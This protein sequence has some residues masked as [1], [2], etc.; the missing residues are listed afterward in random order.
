[1]KPRNGAALALFLF[2]SCNEKP[3]MGSTPSLGPAKVALGTVPASEV[4]VWQ[5]ATPAKS[6]PARYRFAMAYYPTTGKTYV[7]G[8][9]GTQSN[10]ILGDL[11]AWDGKTWTQLTADV[12]PPARVWSAM[13]YDPARDSLILYGGEGKYS[14]GIR[15]D[16]TWEWTDAK[17]WTQLKP[18]SSTGPGALYN[19]QM[20]TDTIRKKVLLGGSNE[21]WEW[22]G[23]AMTWSRRVPPV[24]AS[25]EPAGAREISYDE[26]R[27]KLFIYTGMVGASRS[28]FWELDLLSGGAV[29]RDTGDDLGGQSNALLAY[30]SVRRRH[31]FF[32]G[33]GDYPVDAKSL[34]MWEVDT[35]APTWYVRTMAT[36][37]GA[38][39]QS[40]MVFD[41]GRNV[42]V[43]FGGI[44]L[45]YCGCGDTDSSFVT[46]NE[47]W[48]YKVT[49]LGNGEGCTP[50]TAASCASGNCVE[51]VCCDVAACAGKCTSCNVPGSEGTCVAAKAGAEVQGSCADGLAC[52]GSGDCKTKN[53][54]LCA[55]ASECASG[56]CVDGVCCESD[57][58]GTCKACNVEG[59]TG[60]CQPYPVGTDPQN[61]C[62]KG[63]GA[64]KS[65][66]D[67]VGACV[68]PGSRVTCDSCWTCDGFG[69]CSSHVDNCVPSGGTGGN[70]NPTGGKGGNP[71]GGAGGGTYLV[72]GTGG[73]PA[74]GGAGGASTGR[75]CA[76]GTISNLGGI[77]GGIP[78]HNGGVLG[79][80]GSIGGNT[81]GTSGTS[82]TGGA[83]G[84]VG[85]TRGSTGGTVGSMPGSGGSRA[86]AAT[87]TGGGDAA[88][89]DA[90]LGKSNKSGCSCKLGPRPSSPPNIALLALL[91]GPLLLRKRR[92][93]R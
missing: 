3:Q 49:G 30:D 18:S 74:T 87:V 25:S 24:V 28:E 79:S 93:R 37:P 59:Q 52:D 27:Q 77:D 5:K 45:A 4:A 32:V 88:A 31:V 8:G 62:G 90:A 68:Y 72:D 81:G 34:R 75:G 47:I 66:C 40:S 61:E 33:T 23:G 82:G 36:F 57:C 84:A 53:G 38:L 20:V 65:T 58:T 7:F 44:A 29:K 11:W 85:G 19:L 17:K 73:R 35:K 41:S 16:D 39:T 60:R 42:M 14:T 67:G 22:D 83:I 80:G 43:H 91:S 78:E 1:M 89:V 12:G 64:C 6:P 50:G 13:A 21:V 15:Y 54:Q 48:E 55:A 70:A 46:S 69:S 51:G 56:F 71:S 86:D 63:S 92:D 26:G 2:A 10:N 9:A 76:A